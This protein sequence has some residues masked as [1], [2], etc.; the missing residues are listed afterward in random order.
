[1]GEFAAFAVRRDA[2]Q[3]HQV[4][5]PHGEERDDERQRHDVQRIHAREQ[6]GSGLAVTE[7]KHHEVFADER[8]AL[9]DVESDA[10]RIDRALVPAQHVTRETHHDDG[11]EE[12]HADQPG[13][14]ARELVTGDEDVAQHVPQRHHH[15]QSGGPIV[16]SAHE[17]AEGLALRQV[18]HAQVGRVGVR[19]VGEH[20]ADAGDDEHAEE[21]HHGG[22]VAEI[23]RTLGDA[24]VEHV[25]FERRPAEAIGNPV[26]EAL[27][28]PA[29]HQAEGGME[30]RSISRLPASS[31]MA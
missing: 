7:D 6:P 30:S 20:H 29:F 23:P 1:M 24:A 15:E 16:Q 8:H 14:F 17:P 28:E 18:A 13:A 2:V 27:F 25:V 21:H 31:R 3:D 12:H 19:R 26:D 11:G 5:V 9:E 10:H 4:E 22:A